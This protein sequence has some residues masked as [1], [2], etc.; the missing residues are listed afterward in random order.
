MWF[1]SEFLFLDRYVWLVQEISTIYCHLFLILEQKNEW[2]T[3]LDFTFNLDYYFRND[4]LIIVEKLFA[5]E[6]CVTNLS[7][8]NCYWNFDFNFDWWGFFS[9]HNN[10]DPP[11]RASTTLE[12]TF[13]ILLTSSK[14][15]VLLVI[16]D[17]FSDSHT[18]R[19]LA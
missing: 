4:N 1:S 9:T 7:Y 14:I 15:H 8:V 11:F 6:I 19:I 12:S 5:V 18:Y 3:L 16:Q 2:A 13:Y 17:I 10:D